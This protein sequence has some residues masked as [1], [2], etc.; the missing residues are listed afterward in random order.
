MLETIDYN[1]QLL[2][3]SRT[4]YILSWLPEAYDRTTSNQQSSNADNGR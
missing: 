4:V 1:A 2:G 3:V